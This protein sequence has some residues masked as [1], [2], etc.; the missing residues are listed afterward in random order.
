MLSTKDAQKLYDTSLQIHTQILTDHGNVL[1]RPHELAIQAI[2]QTLAGMVNAECPTW[3]GRWG[4]AAPVGFGKSSAIAAFLSAAWQLK[5]LGN[6]VTM[7]LTASRVAQLFDFE[8]AI[9]NAGIPKAE[10]RKYLSVVYFTPKKA[11]EGASRESDTNYDAPILLVTHNKIRQ[12]YNRKERWGHQPKDLVYFLKAHDEPRDLVVWDERCS[13]TDPIT[14]SI[15][16]IG[17]ARVCLESVDRQGIMFPWVDQLYQH[18]KQAAKTA[19]DTQKQVMVE[20][21][22][23]IDDLSRHYALLKQLPRSLYP[24]A[25]ENLYLLIDLLKFPVRVL[26]SGLVSYQQVV[27]DCVENLLVLDAS[28]DTASLNKMDTSIQNLEDAHPILLQVQEIY[29]K[30]LKQLKDCSDLSFTHWNHG[31]GKDV[32]ERD[33]LA[34]LDGN[35]VEGNVVH[36]VVKWLQPRVEQGKAVLV[37]THKTTP[38]IKDLGQVVRRCLSKAFDLS[39]TIDDPYQLVRDDQ[40]N[41]VPQPRPQITVETYGKLDAS[42]EFYYCDVTVSLGIQERDDFDLESQAIAK[43]RDLAALVTPEETKLAKLTEKAVVY[44]QSHGRGQSRIMVDGKA[45]PQEHFAIYPENARTGSLTDVLKPLYFGATW[46]EYKR[47]T[48]TKPDG[49]I[50][51]WVAVVKAYLSELQRD[52]ISSRELKQAVGAEG[53]AKGT[54]R[55]VTRRVHEDADC[56][57][58]MIGST[59]WNHLRVHGIKAA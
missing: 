56:L 28:F 8:Q 58:T 25:R 29:G 14:L 1:N 55:E 9:I 21:L 4:I 19:Q 20:K 43:R 23:T 31:G 13:T 47:K 48:T 17:Q 35:D 16:Q 15:E 33:V 51:H 45:L 5:L 36:E 44:E 53:V 10:I 26:P 32:I 6:G 30:R 50:A 7:T 39:K 52:S 3:F 12:V 40:G 46:I 34:Y 27:P 59:F 57:W 54:W 22:A 24:N 18:L 38:G 49:V 2:H 37:A 42:N 11:V 41:L